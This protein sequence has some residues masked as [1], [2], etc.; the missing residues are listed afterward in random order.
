MSD[1]AG[2][3]ADAPFAIIAATIHK[4]HMKE[5]RSDSTDIYSLA[6]RHCV[7][8]VVAFMHAQ[9]QSDRS[10][11][12]L[13]ERRGKVED[14]QLI[15]AFHDICHGGNCWGELSNL[16]IDLIDKKA[17]MTG[18]QIADLVSTPI[19]RH[20]LQPNEP[21]RAFEV[22][23]QKIWLPPWRCEREGLPTEHPG[24]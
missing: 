4:R 16:S 3:L 8:N 15:A 1:L 22:I 13:I 23:R 10:I 21:S 20:M 5:A 9:G 18:L 2:T 7:E 19:G 24:K 14:R 17:N 11:P 6:L 12:F